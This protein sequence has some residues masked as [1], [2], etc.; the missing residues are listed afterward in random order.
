M[1]AK[2]KKNF[3][4]HGSILAMAGILVRVIGMFYRI[5]LM[6]IIGSEGNGIYSV[7]FNIYNI[8]LVLS[9]YGLPMAVSKLI[10]ERIAKEEY[11]NA[12]KL[13]RASLVISF[14]TG[15]LACFIL[16]AGSG[17]FEKIYKGVSGLAIPLKVLAPTLLVVA[18]MGVVRGFF[19][20][21]GNM[22]PTAMSQLIEQVMNAFVSVFAAYVLVKTHASSQDLAAY[23]AAGG[24]L[25]TLM[26]A[27]SGFLFLLL[28]LISKM[29]AF[30][31]EV[32]H[33]KL[34]QDLDQKLLY[35]MII[36]TVV[37][38]IIGQTLY[39]ISAVIDDMMFSNI[40][41]KTLSDSKIKSDLGNFASSYSLLISIPQGV[42]SAMSASMLP[43]VVE[44][45]TKGERKAVRR[46]IGNTI[47]TNMFVAFPSFVGLLVLGKPIIKLLFSRYDA[48]QGTV[49]LY[50]GAIAVVFYTLSTVSSSALQGV[51]RMNIPVKHS[52]I[53]L[54][55]HIVLV[56]LL[57]RWSGL[58]IYAIVIGNASFPCLIFI[59]NFKS[60]KKITGFRF[61]Y[62]ISVM[63]PLVSALAMGLTTKIT[64]NLV[65]SLV[66]INFI[67]LV[68]AMAVAFVTYAAMLMQF[69]KRNMY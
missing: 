30:N 49:M 26:G 54:L 4:V 48:N 52:G 28:L 69:K 57:L 53:S 20:G 43:S 60:L 18:V 50:L 38:I 55:V 44:S 16:F 35:K 46:K 63:V 2:E 56:Y 58:G 9:S 13:F 5:P 7:A 19:Q 40:M 41:A 6:N 22:I 61:N 25:G 24:T 62:K 14:I 47:T 37:P 64:Y 32:K 11:R 17:I 68:F 12:K 45:Y 8:A 10:S 36:I 3:L 21:Q 65:Y 66:K 31:Y 15:G 59:L 39:Q 23:G 51:D 67:A 42:A 34:S 1:A 33:D 27:A 29:G